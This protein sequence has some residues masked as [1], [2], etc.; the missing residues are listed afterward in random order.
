MKVKYILMIAILVALLFP[1][2][3]TCQ[4]KLLIIAPDEFID[5]LKPLKRF[6][7]ATVRPTI[8]LSLN[9]V[10]N[11]FNGV[12]E[13]E[14]IKRCIAYYE[15]EYSVS[16]V[17]LVGDVDKFPVRWRWWGYVGENPDGTLAYNTK[18]DQRGWAVSDL[19]YADLYKTG[20]QHLMTGTPT[21]MDF[22]VRSNS[23]QT[24]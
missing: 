21:I 10:Y 5:E 13:P 24:R 23:N 19:Y 17:M 3:A 4:D 22:M 15:D 18:D 7:D 1:F 14:Q 11:S 20:R 8:L 6:K 9:D 16:F 2:P 12:D